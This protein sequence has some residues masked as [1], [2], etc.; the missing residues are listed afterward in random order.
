MVLPTKLEGRPTASPSAAVRLSMPKSCTHT[1]SCRPVTKPS[2]M[3]GAW[4]GSAKKQCTAS[5]YTSFSPKATPPG[6]PPTPQG[7]KAMRGCSSSTVTPLF[8]Q[9]PLEAPGGHRVAQKQ[10]HRILVVYKI[11]FGVFF[12]HP[13]PL[14]HCFAVIVRVFHHG[15]ALVCAA[16]PS[17]TGGR[18]PT[19]AHVTRNPNLALI[20]PMDSPRLPVEPTAIEYCE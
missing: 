7:K 8:C 12:R 5:P 14:F 18:L 16:N 6:P 1:W 9:L 10:V 11:T 20:M 17:S 19:C 3:Q 4:V 15:H 13:A 2:I